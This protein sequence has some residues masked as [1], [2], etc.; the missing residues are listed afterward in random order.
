MRVGDAVQRGGSRTTGRPGVSGLVDRMAIVVPAGSQT[1]EHACAGIAATVA[2]G[3]ASVR[4]RHNERMSFS[5]LRP[6]CA[7]E[8]RRAD[9]IR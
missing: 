4:H 3:A 2:S 6:A 5:L 1:V 7:V 8:L 9:D